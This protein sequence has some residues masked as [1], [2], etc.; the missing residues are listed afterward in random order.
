MRNKESKALCSFSVGRHPCSDQCYSPF[1]L[2]KL[3]SINYTLLGDK[4]ASHVNNGRSNKRP[5]TLLN[6]F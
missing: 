2:Y 1:N 4:K 5:V 6:F 3:F